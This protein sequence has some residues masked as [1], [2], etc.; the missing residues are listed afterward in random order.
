[1]L[2][3]LVPYG[4]AQGGENK[5]LIIVIHFLFPFRKITKTK[6][7]YYTV[8]ISIKGFFLG[9]SNDQDD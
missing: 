8:T 6:I 9:K 4:S 2:Y 5:K 7:R 1:M 3:I